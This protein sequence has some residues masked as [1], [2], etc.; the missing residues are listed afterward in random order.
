MLTVGYV[1]K[2]RDTTDFRLSLIDVQVCSINY[3]KTH[4]QT[5]ILKLHE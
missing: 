4:D 3:R 1:Y 5:Q 2:L